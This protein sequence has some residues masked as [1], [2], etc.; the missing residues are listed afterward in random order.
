MKFAKRFYQSKKWKECRNAYRVYRYGICERCG[1]PGGIVH[2]KI[3]LNEYNIK[4]PNISLSFDNLELLCIDCHNAEHL[5]ADVIAEGLTFD[6]DGNL[7]KYAPQYNTKIVNI[8]SRGS[9]LQ[10]PRKGILTRPGL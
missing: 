8:E 6:E 3:Y 1:K 5:A 4:D 7:I 10:K 9:Y 2:H